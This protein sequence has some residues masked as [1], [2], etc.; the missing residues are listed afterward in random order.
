MPGVESGTFRAAA[1]PLG[2]SVH[3]HVVMRAGATRQEIR[4]LAVSYREVQQASATFRGADVVVHLGETK[5][6]PDWS[7]SGLDTE[8]IDPGKAVDMWLD[9]RDSVGGNVTALIGPITY[10]EVDLPSVQPERLGEVF[11]AVEGINTRHAASLRRSPSWR[12]TGRTGGTDVRIQDVAPEDYRRWA[13]FIDE[14]VRAAGTDSLPLV[15]RLEIAHT[16]AQKGRDLDL[17]LVFGLPAVGASEL[18]EFRPASGPESES[19]AQAIARINAIRGDLDV[20]LSIEMQIL[21]RDSS[22]MHIATVGEDGCDRRGENAALWQK[23]FVSSGAKD[24]KDLHG[25]CVP[26]PIG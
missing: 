16:A 5:D 2:I 3:S 23:L 1:S 22:P 19:V 14:L 8:T 25:S 26:E 13:A 10:L 6:V 18:R 4:Q 12:F 21:D 15:D 17:V 9:A 20:R 7:M 24:G 11:D